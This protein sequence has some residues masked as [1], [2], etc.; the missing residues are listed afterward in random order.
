MFGEVSLEFGQ[1]VRDVELFGDDLMTA[2]NNVQKTTPSPLFRD[3]INDL[4]VVYETK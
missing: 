1:V 2:L 3:F 4:G